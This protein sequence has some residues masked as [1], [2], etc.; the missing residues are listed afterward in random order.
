MSGTHLTAAAVALNAAQPDADKETAALRRLLPVLLSLCPFLKV[1][2]T[3]GALEATALIQE[4]NPAGMDPEGVDV[5]TEDDDPEIQLYE[6]AHILFI[7]GLAYKSGALQAIPYP[8]GEGL[9]TDFNTHLGVEAARE[10]ADILAA[11]LAPKVSLG[12]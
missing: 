3:S 4:V 2:L 11:S 7:L 12:K 10:T 8:P 9:S 1:P 6:S 5:Q